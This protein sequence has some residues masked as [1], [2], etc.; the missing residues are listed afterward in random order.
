MISLILKQMDVHMCHESPVMVF[1]RKK[2]NKRI[3]SSNEKKK[4]EN[5]YDIF[6][7]NVGCQLSCLDLYTV[8]CEHCN[9]PIKTGR[10]INGYTQHGSF[11]D[12][13]LY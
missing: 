13:N 8:I 2:V 3:I 10:K 9:D 5:K 7:S 11:V 6:Y 12:Q 1:Y 4:N